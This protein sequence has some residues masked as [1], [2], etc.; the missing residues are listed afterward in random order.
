[1]C[2]K[3]VYIYNVCVFIVYVYYIYIHSIYEFLAS[4]VDPAV[5][6]EEV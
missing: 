3:Y 1:M 5:L 6:S 2:I 4:P